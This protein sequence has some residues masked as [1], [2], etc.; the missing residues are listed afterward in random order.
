ME[1]ILSIENL[2]VAFRQEEGDLVAV[3]GVSLSL[4]RGETLALVGESGCG[5]T[6]LCKSMLG[7]LCEKGEIRQGAIRLE[8]R[9]LVCCSEE[10]HER[11]RG[12]EIAMVFQ[13][14]M[15]SLNPTVSVG[16]QVAEVVRQHRK[17]SRR[18]AKEKAV[19]LLS[20]CGMDN[21]RIR[22]GQLPH[23]LSGGMRQRAAIAIALAGEPKLLL[24]DEPTTA[25][26]PESREQILRLLS[27]L[28]RAFSVSMIFI[29]HDLSLAERI[30]DKVAVMKAGQ[31]VEQGTITEVFGRPRHAYTKKL[32]GYVDYERGVSHRHGN[33]EHEKE[34][35]LEARDL[36]FR[37]R[38]DLRENRAIFS[39]LSLEIFRGEILGII[40]PSGCGKTTLARCLAGILKPESGEITYHGKEP[41]RKNRIQMIFQDS[42]SAMNQR[43]TVAEIVGEPLRIRERKN[44]A[45][46]RLAALLNQAELSE[47]F[48]ERYPYELS[49]GQ[50]QRVAIARALAADPELIIA[51]EP[52]SSLDVT[53]AAQIIHLFKRLQEEG[54]LT[55]LLIAHDL[56][57]V[58]HVADRVMELS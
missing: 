49:G 47:T 51:D 44:P 7:I 45:R 31:I 4:P 57:M 55:I 38:S 27:D 56:P 28:A 22:S 58:R 43:M 3:N 8:G 54:N 46:E 52:V 5:K 12:K 15:A 10:E 53:V 26:D 13:D 18:E 39:E 16:E 48:L 50:R 11:L 40:G 37:Y 30:A 2:T 25:L 35:L 1:P 42:F 29:T 14:P 41:H 6:V 34:L 23:V 24:A 36:T 33:K 21:P 32:L 17:V 20:L 19:H 9:D